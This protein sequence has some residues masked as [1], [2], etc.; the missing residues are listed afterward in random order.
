[1]QTFF[2]LDGTLLLLG[3]TGKRAYQTAV[4]ILDVPID[5]IAAHFMYHVV[6]PFV[7]IEVVYLRR[8]SGMLAGGP[9]GTCPPERRFWGRQSNIIVL[10]GARY[11]AGNAIGMPSFVCHST[12]IYKR[13][14]PN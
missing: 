1:M 5:L 8:N 13:T 10:W 3:K 2:Q 7:V 11:L 12:I 9:G 14:M 4:V 6:F